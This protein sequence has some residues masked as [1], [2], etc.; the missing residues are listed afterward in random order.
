M[1]IGA[2]LTPLLCLAAVACAPAI[3]MGPDP[4]GAPIVQLVD[5][6]P[7]AHELGEGFL[8]RVEVRVAGQVDTIA[9]VLT[10]ELPLVIGSARLL[11]FGFE[12]DAITYA[13]EYDMRSGRV[14]HRD[15]PGDF[16]PIFSAPSFAPD[17]RY[18]AYVVTRGDATGWGV[19]RSWPQHRLIVRSDAA[20]VPATDSPGHFTHW[21][22]ADSAEL[23]I[24]T[25]FS[26]WER[27]VSGARIRASPT[28]PPDRH[29]PRSALEIE[30]SPA[31]D[32]HL[33][34]SPSCRGD[35]LRQ[36]P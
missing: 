35:D 4:A 20:E 29:H 17:G 10:S 34:T 25:G 5:S 11:G 8:Y 31:P 26:T 28:G 22:S 2:W 13:Y 7:W 18:I 14:R 32:E 30:P 23:F 9:G 24:E 27:L 3:R 36:H 15:L 1:R 21:L 16:D 6:I 19:V 12:A 33:W